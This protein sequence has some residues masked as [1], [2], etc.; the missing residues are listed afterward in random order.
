MLS[1]TELLFRLEA[2][3][4]TLNNLQTE[5]ASH[6]ENHPYGPD[7]ERCVFCPVA[8]ATDNIEKAIRRLN[9]Q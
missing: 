7:T 4:V 8:D 9:L 2:V 1:K 6:S 5:A 3:K